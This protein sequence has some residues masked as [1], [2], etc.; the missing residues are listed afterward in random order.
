METKKEKSIDGFLCLLLILPVVFFCAYVGKTLWWWFVVPLGA[1]A[2][3]MAQAYGIDILVSFWMM[4]LP[5]NEA[6][7]ENMAGRTIKKMGA[8]ALCLLGGWIAHKL[9][10]R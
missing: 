2:I 4:R 1:P 5:R 8:V 6:D 9:M 3:G 10:L 7:D